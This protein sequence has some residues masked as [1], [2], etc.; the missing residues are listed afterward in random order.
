M[1]S[2]QQKNYQ[3][4]LSTTSTVLLPFADLS[5]YHPAAGTPNLIGLLMS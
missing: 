1:K 4:I 2:H 3:G 5:F